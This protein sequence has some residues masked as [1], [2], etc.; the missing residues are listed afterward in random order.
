MNKSFRDLVAFKRAMELMVEVYKA[1]KSF[2]REETYGLTSQLRRAAVGV[3]SQIA[4]GEGRLT[5]GEWR[6]FLSQSR[7]SLFEVEAECIAAEK[8]GYLSVEDMQRLMRILNGAGRALTGLINWVRRK[9]TAQPRNRVT[10]QP[11]NPTSP[12]Q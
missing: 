3:V 4:E 7:G 8:L 10:P 1:T 2:P 5:F 9:E 11:R 12:P 6:Q